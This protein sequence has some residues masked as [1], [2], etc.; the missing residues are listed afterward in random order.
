MQSRAIVTVSAVVSGLA[1][2]ASAARA[3][4]PAE[5]IAVI[6]HG[7]FFELN[8]IDPA[9]FT[10]AQ[11]D[12]RLAQDMAEAIAAWFR[13]RPEQAPDFIVV[14]K[15]WSPPDSLAFYQAKA[16]DVAGIGVSEFSG[17]RPCQGVVY[18]SSFDQYDEAHLGDAFFRFAW[19]QELAHRWGAYVGIDN[20]G[21]TSDPLRGRAQSHWSYFVDT[22]WSALQG[23]DW[24]DNGDGTFTTDLA[25][26]D[27][28]LLYSPL[29]LYL[30][31]L[32][33]AGAVPDSFW[34][35]EP[36]GADRTADS[37]PEWRV[38]GDIPVT[39]TGVRRDV[40]I[41]DIIAVA[42]PRDPSFADAPRRFR[43]AMLVLS[44]LGAP[45]DAGAIATAE[46]FAARMAD[47]VARHTRHLAALDIRTGPPPDDAPPD[48]V[49]AVAVDDR[50]VTLD[51][52]AS[53]DPDGTPL[54]FAWDFGDGTGAFGDAPVVEH[55]YAT[56][57]AHT[58]TTV[59]VDRAGSATTTTTDVTIDNLADCGCAASTRT[60]PTDAL[61][62]LLVAWWTRRRRTRSDPVETPN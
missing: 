43:V 4:G 17:T 60:N 19:A 51:A 5:P 3:G 47:E 8:A 45:L 57:G 12:G 28:A 24:I 34:I 15:G 20:V 33:P 55:A 49:I 54:A 27:G 29:D 11:H 7:A 44:Q 35:D 53:S 46:S 23:N 62:W 37:P 1:A 58:V 32:V 30:M 56:S 10:S 52:G 21:G 25:S 26:V 18:M 48:V 2:A 39:V 22:D 16:N 41:G 50:T 9:V 61:P 42:G 38:D 6:D 59:A 40:A 13:L 14:Y 31:G 36:T